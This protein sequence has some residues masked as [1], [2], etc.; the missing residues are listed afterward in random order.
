MAIS[1]N[2]EKSA[3]TLRLSLEKAGITQPPVVE[4][5]FNMDVSGS[6]ED[7]HMDGLTNDVMTR[8]VPWGL[9]FDPDQK[10]DFFTFS[11]NHGGRPPAYYVGEVTAQNYQGYIQREVI[12]K[13]PNWNGGTLFVPVL[14]MNRQHFGWVEGPKPTPAV[15][16][17]EKK[18]IFSKLFGGGKEEAP[19]PA[20]PTP[21]VAPVQR[22]T[23]I[24]FVTDGANDDRD[25]TERLLEQMQSRGEQI[26]IQFFAMN[27]D[28]SVRFE[29]LQHVADRFDNTGL[30]ICRDI[31]AFTNMSDEEINEIMISEELIDWLKK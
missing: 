7:E 30:Y 5:G 26:Y 12:R 17:A 10:L 4:V 20:A 27:N 2:L 25:A 29:F 13:V 19:A 14:Q 24:L 1:V 21:V 15:A 18:G 9:V 23:L 28:P 6:F 31:K 3:A 16:P 22:K 8:L 11:S